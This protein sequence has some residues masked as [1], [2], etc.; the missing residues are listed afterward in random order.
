MKLAPER[1]SLVKPGLSQLFI[2]EPIPKEV[3]KILQEFE[4][5]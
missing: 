4:M 2:P 5:F 3:H 1:P